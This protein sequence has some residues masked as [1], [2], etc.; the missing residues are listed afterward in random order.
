MHVGNKESTGP[1]C[2]TNQEKDLGV[3][4]DPGSKFSCRVSR[5]MAKSDQVLAW[6]NQPWFL[7]SQGHKIQSVKL[8]YTALVR[9]H[10]NY[11]NGVCHPVFKKDINLLER[12]HRLAESQLQKD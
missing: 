9:P 2:I 10:L 4:F 1:L 12:V 7:G 8:L 6:T 3:W 5:A 11:D